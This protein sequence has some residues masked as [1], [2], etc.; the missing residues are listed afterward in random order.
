M[1]STPGS[2]LLATI[3][4]PLTITKHG[5]GPVL[6]ACL[7]SG[8]VMHL[9]S[10]NSFSAFDNHTAWTRSRVDCQIGQWVGDAAIQFKWEWIDINTHVLAQAETTTPFPLEYNKY[11]RAQPWSWQVADRA[12]ATLT[13]NCRHCLI[14]L[15]E[16]R[17]WNVFVGFAERHSETQG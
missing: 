9:S 6:S 14:G 5:Q 17:V 13:G 8:L 11:L 16:T 10:C 7:V 12:C 15:P 3:S 4:Q 1:H 2:H